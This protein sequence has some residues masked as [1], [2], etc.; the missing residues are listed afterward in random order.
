MEYALDVNA[1]LFLNMFD[2]LVDKDITQLE[3]GRFMY[4]P[5]GTTPCVLHF[6]G[7]SKDLLL[8]PLSMRAAPSAWVTQASVKLNAS[9]TLTLTLT[10]TLTPTLALTLTPT[11]ALTLTLTLPLTRR[12]SS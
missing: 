5:T 4:L 10:P 11:L 8:K 3:D 6:N 1:T 9:I 2:V 12:A 7:K